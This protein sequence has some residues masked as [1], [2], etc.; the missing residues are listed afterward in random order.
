MY[1]TYILLS[2]K[3]NQFYAGYT[4][5]LKLRFEQHSKGLV[6]PTKNRRPLKL[7]YYEACL[8][9]KDALKR[10]KY[11]KT[12]YG[13]M[14][15]RNRLKSYFTGWR[16][17]KLWQKICG[18]AFSKIR[19]QK[20]AETNRCRVRPLAKKRKNIS[21]ADRKIWWRCPPCYPLWWKIPLIWQWNFFSTSHWC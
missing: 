10:E 14:F 8:N 4:Q 7:I 15:L 18:S 17:Q 3:D 13:K 19:K 1:Y 21:K 6:E 2:E 12:H 20:S 11:F 5:N 16:S 9:Q